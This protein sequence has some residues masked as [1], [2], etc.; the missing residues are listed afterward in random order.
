MN[1]LVLGGCGF[2][3][4]YL[5]DRLRASGDDVRVMDRQPELFRPPV[6]DV[7]YH[8]GDFGNRAFLHS[9]LRGR[10]IVY[11]LINT[12]VP[13]TSN[14]DPAFDVTS[15][16]VETLYLLDQC[17]REGVRKV[18]FLSSGGAVYGTPAAVPVPEDAPTDPESSYGIAKLTIEKYL[19]LYRRLHRLDY[20]I[21]RPSNPYGPRQNP[22]GAQGIVAVS[23]A[24]IDSGR[25]VE[26]WG[27]G[28]AVKDY[29]YVD[30]VADGIHRAGVSPE[31]HGVFNL[32]SGVGMTVNELLA[33]IAEVAGRPME[34]VHAPRMRHD[35]PRIVLD[36]SRA[37][38]KLAW[39]P[40]VPLREGL[41]RT[42]AFITSL[43]GR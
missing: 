27:D 2:I 25:P 5:V 7:E 16:V 6:P 28:E 18:V 31:P 17:A 9:T 13:A 10:E 32:G 22:H 4:S 19:A 29:V 38:Q 33:L 24:R 11:H 34:V 42:W 30:D 23:M 20:A 36:V 3:G 40:G 8:F 15:N 12:T 14:D 26:V 21:V 43:R 1:A 35:V 41:E 39:Q 37:K